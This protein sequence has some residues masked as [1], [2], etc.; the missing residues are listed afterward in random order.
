MKT[1]HLPHLAR[2]VGGGGGGGGGASG[3]GFSS[4]GNGR[5]GSGDG[6]DS[7]DGDVCLRFLNAFLSVVKERVTS[8]DPKD[9][10]LF[11][12]E[13]RKDIVIW[14]CQNDSNFVFLP[15]WFLSPTE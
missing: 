1:L 15:E 5:S 10:V 3:G 11:A 14:E 12:F 13:P 9:V 8:P 7:W 4:S 6:G 2:Q